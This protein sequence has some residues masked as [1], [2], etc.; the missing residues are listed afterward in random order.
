MLY[1]MVG[2]LVGVAVGWLLRARSSAASPPEPAALRPA[3]AA[4]RAATSDG[5]TI[6]PPPSLSLADLPPSTGPRP[7]ENVL[8]GV[9]GDAKG[10]TFAIGRRIVTIGRSP[11][12]YVQTMDSSVSRVHCQLRADDAGMWLTDMTSENGTL[13][14]DTVVRG[15]KVKIADGDVI[16]VGGSVF[17]FRAGAVVGEDAAQKP[18]R[19]DAAAKA[20]TAPLAGGEK[21][22]HELVMKALDAAN[23]DIRGAADILQVDV[24]AVVEILKHGRG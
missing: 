18:K 22:L 17:R 5:D 2:V 6:P 8:E 23:G 16:T 1:L 7:Q 13:V 19:A 4:P 11:A 21:T 10:K 15:K 24:H 9:L 20:E 3:P 12:N 14:N